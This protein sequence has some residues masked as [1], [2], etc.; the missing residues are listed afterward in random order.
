[1]YVWGVS[2]QT[3]MFASAALKTLAANTQGRVTSQ[4]R[5]SMGMAARLRGLQ[6]SSNKLTTS[7]AELVGLL[8]CM[9]LMLHL[10]LQLLKQLRMNQE[11][12]NV[13]LN[14]PSISTPVETNLHVEL[15]SGRHMS[16][17]MQGRPAARFH[18]IFAV[19]HARDS[20]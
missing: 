6:H 3:Y 9:R 17:V 1:M 10:Q 8:I 19:D 5:A 4:E 12:K 16:Y 7:T 13:I 18:C 15:C 11:S 20:S 2:E 14:Q